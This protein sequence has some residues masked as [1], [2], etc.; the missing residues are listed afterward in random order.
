MAYVVVRK[1]L[2]VAIFHQ[3]ESVLNDENVALWR[4]LSDDERIAVQSVIDAKDESHM[5]G[6]ATLLLNVR[7]DACAAGGTAGYES[8]LVDGMKAIMSQL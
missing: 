6:F 1:D 5:Q 8:G 4:E 2:S 3:E 7:C